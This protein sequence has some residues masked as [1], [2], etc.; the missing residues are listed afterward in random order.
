MRAAHLGLPLLLAALCGCAARRGPE[1]HADLGAGGEAEVELL[2]LVARFTATEGG[3]V[4]LLLT[5]RQPAWEGARASTLTWETFVDRR[6]FASGKMDLGKQPLDVTGRRPLAITLP[7]VYH[8]LELR[9]G[10]ARLQIR[11]RGVLELQRGA[12]VWTRIFDRSQETAVDG[13]PL[14]PGGLDSER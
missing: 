6:L 3:R 8:H 2:S 13:A 1:A 5:V 11:I 9:P 10:P 14:P 12:A 4:D 7:L